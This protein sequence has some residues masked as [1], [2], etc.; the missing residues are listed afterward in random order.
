VLFRAWQAEQWPIAT[1][2]PKDEYGREVERM[3]SYIDH[4]PERHHGEAMAMQYVEVLRMPYYDVLNLP[5]DEFVRLSLL[6]KA[7]SMRRPAKFKGEEAY[8]MDRT[9]AKYGLR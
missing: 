8:Y 4:V 7:V 5:Y 6:H 2:E 3:Q 9:R 1:T